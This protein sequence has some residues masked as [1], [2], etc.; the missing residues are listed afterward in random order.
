M[1]SSVLRPRFRVR[2]MEQTIVRHEMSWHVRLLLRYDAWVTR[3]LRLP[4]L[5][6]PTA[7]ALRRAQAARYLQ[8]L[9]PILV[10]AMLSAVT[11]AVVALYYGWRLFPLAWASWVTVT[12]WA[13]I[14]RIRRV[15][16]RRRTDA[17]SQ[18]FVARIILDTAIVAM[19]WAVLP[20]VVHPSVAPEMEVI[21]ATMLAGLACAGVFIMAIIP[22]AGA[23][24]LA[25][26]MIGRIVQLGFMPLD[27]AVPN[28]VQQA[29]YGVALVLALRTMALLFIE[30]VQAS[31]VVT[32]LG[33]EAQERASHEA[34]RRTQM[35]HLPG[36]FKETVSRPLQQMSQAVDQ[37][38]GAATELSEI[39]TTSRL[40]LEELLATVAE[41][42]GGMRLVEAESLRL[43]E[44]IA[45]VL[46]AA[47]ET[48]ALVQAAAAEVASSIAVKEQLGSA[49][50]DIERIADLISDIARQT[51]LLALNATI[52]AA[53]AGPEGKGF[54]VVAREVKLLASRTEAATE[55]ICNRIK[56]VRSAAEDSLSAS[57]TIGNS[58]NAIVTVSNGIIVAADLQAN[59]VAS[60][61]EAVT[62]GVA[63]AERAALTIE[64]VASRTAQTLSQ[65]A[66]VSEAA[67]HVDRSTRDLAGVVETFTAGIVAL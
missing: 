14:A 55:E 36:D 37:M 45:M 16:E 35:Q 6:G 54:V 4:H 65:G 3:S 41:T 23:L 27:H 19:P 48:A 60:I 31:A 34:Q 20:I 46:D 18:R 52:E 10:S 61:V 1:R 66:Q 59:G 11:I 57:R 29:M 12:A 44:S 62:H 33:E 15:R 39:S 56:V 38:N 42:K 40:G 47:R 13:G 30:H 63:A 26:L 22:S 5:T 32:S 67:G 24:F 25:M 58:A 51:N 43:S 64:E 8:T 21:I 50:R 49:V 2:V 9:P 28:L 17:P 7:G 53:R